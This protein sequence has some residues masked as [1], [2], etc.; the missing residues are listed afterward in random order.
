[1]TFRPGGGFMTFQPTTG[2]FIEKCKHGIVVRQCRCP[3]PKI[4]RIVPC[5]HEEI[6]KAPGA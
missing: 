1:M 6:Q 4:E 2:H 3:G 5:A